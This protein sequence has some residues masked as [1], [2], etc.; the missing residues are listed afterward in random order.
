VLVDVHPDVVVL[1]APDGHASTMAALRRLA[2]AD[3]VPIIVTSAATSPRNAC[4]VL[5]AGADDY[6]ARPFDPSELAARV[7]SLVR[8]RGERLANGR[9]RVGRAVVDLD[10]REVVV[11]G[12]VVA[13][14]RSDWRLLTR[15]L[16]SVN[17]VVPQD[18]LLTAGFGR[19]AVGDIASLRAAMGRLRRK[20]G[21]RPGEEGPI[22][23]VR[24]FGYAL[25]SSPNG[26]GATVL[27]Q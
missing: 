11:D 7:R 13:L 24:G 5:D 20:L 4:E 1:D 14:A 25:R 9:R 15:L 18:D 26:E 3:P 10:R 6:L 2:S 19:E 27:Q 23:T 22:R 16:A 21:V 8:R 17:E 12:R